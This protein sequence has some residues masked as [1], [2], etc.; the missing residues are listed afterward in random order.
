M[1]TREKR[2]IHPAEMQLR[3]YAHLENNQWVAVCI[4]FNLAAQADSFEEA[5]DKLHQQVVWYVYD[6]VAGDDQAHGADLLMRKAPVPL[7]VRYH[8]INAVSRVRAMQAR[9]RAFC[10]LLPLSPQMPAAA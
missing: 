3:C 5:R 4:D 8:L 9:V 2:V 1:A 10:D 6:A 7:M